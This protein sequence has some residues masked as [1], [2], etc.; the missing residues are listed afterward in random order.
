MWGRGVK[1]AI[2]HL[3][4]APSTN[5]NDP[6]WQLLHVLPDSQKNRSW[7]LEGWLFTNLILSALHLEG[8]KFN[9]YA[10]F[11]FPNKQITGQ[12]MGPGPGLDTPFPM[13][14]VMA[15]LARALANGM[16]SSPNQHELIVY[17]TDCHM[18]DRV[19]YLRGM[20]NLPLWTFRG[21][22]SATWVGLG[23]IT[24]NPWASH[25][26]KNLKFV[27]LPKKLRPLAWLQNRVAIGF[28]KA[29]LSTKS[30]L[31]AP[32]FQGPKIH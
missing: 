19:T 27:N 4:V 22:V 29:T 15:H 13:M 28:M 26:E 8:P 5:K 2:Q 30:M 18:P 7:I 6:D 12:I 17:D 32:H 21:G 31:S 16:S 10:H 14:G 11:P 1:A 23:P 20:L 3:Q 24:C 9:M 25:E